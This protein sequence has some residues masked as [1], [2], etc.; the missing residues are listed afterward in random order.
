VEKHVALVVA[1]IALVGTLVGNYI[2]AQTAHTTAQLSYQS[3]E[4]ASD[5]KMIEIAV[6]ILRAPITEDV[7]SIRTWAMD[8]I[9]ASSKRK[10]TREERSALLR[11][12]L[13]YLP[14]S[15]YETFE[16]AYCSDFARGAD[17]T[18][19]ASRKTQALHNSYET[20]DKVRTDDLFGLALT[21]RKFGEVLRGNR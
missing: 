20:G 11:K 12:P 7:A 16:P 3:A 21:C 13:A 9:D 19:V 5:I 14:S 18:I 6:G 8:I 2:Q 10:L 15:Q 17:G 1:V 4:H